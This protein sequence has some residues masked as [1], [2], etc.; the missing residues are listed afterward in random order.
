ML[1]R[2]CRSLCVHWLSG[3]FFWADELQQ[4]Q[5]RE[6]T[7]SCCLC[8]CLCVCVKGGMTLR[9]GG[10]SCPVTKPVISEASTS[11][12]ENS[13]FSCFCF[14]AKENN[15]YT[16]YPERPL[17]MMRLNDRWRTCACERD[18]GFSSS[19]WPFKTM[20]SVMAIWLEIV[21]HE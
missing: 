17:E 20:C 13:F 3:F 5:H 10:G 18:L 2:L 14:N 16:V 7:D 11:L 15:T 8:L 4:W 9:V 19:D 21:H 6:L 12:R 1:S